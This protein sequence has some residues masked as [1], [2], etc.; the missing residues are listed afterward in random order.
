MAN[1]KPHIGKNVIETLTLG[2]YENPM[3]IYREYIQNAADQIDIAVEQKLLEN[4]S[5]GLVNITIDS[6]NRRITIEDNATGI[7]KKKVS[8]FLS[9][10]ANSEKDVNKRKG[11]RGIGRLGGLGYCDKLIF[12]TSSK[13]ENIKSVLTLNASYLREIL[14]NVKDTRDA[15]SVIS[16]ITKMSEAKE[17][18]NSHYFKVHLENVLSDELLK[19]DKVQEYLSLVAPIPFAPDPVEE[20]DPEEDNFSHSKTIASYYKTRGIIFDEYVVKINDSQIFKAYKDI[21]KFA[22]GDK[23]DGH[24][25]TISFFDVTDENDLLLAIGWYGISDKVNYVIEKE[26]NPERGIRIRK[27]N[28]AIGDETSLYPRFKNDRTNLRYIGEIHVSATGFI[29][30]ARRDYFNLNRTLEQFEKSLDI[31]FNDFESKLPYVASN[32][33]NRLKTIQD[34]RAKI[35]KYKQDL[36]SDKFQTTEEREQR[37]LEVQK[38]LKSAQSATLKIEKIKDDGLKNTTTKI[39]FKSI[40][41]DYKYNISNKELDGLYEKRIIPPLKFKKL[42]VDQSDLLNEVVIFLQKELGYQYAAELIKKLQKNYN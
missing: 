4:R 30:N 40:V 20:N 37:F 3:F 25:T 23:K 29:P 10:V 15:S 11:F 22:K 6:K 9:D 42:S 18:V 13:G 28:I 32:L 1:R 12:E 38:S 31:I 24:I 2:M 34:T 41:A 16:A 21:L 14:D 36:D 27:S 26:G 39:L 17:D 8:K 5:D 7:S 33:H 19:T 35:V